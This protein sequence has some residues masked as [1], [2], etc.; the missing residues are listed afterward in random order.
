[1]ANVSIDYVGPPFN[2]ALFSE[3]SAAFGKVHCR[4]FGFRDKVSAI[5]D[6]AASSLVGPFSEFCSGTD[7]AEYDLIF[8][9]STRC[10]F[11][12]Q[13]I[14]PASK[15]LCCVHNVEADYATFNKSNIFTRTNIASS[16]RR[17]L[18]STAKLLFMHEDDRKRMEELYGVSLGNFGYHPVCSFGTKQPLLPVQQRKSRIAFVGSLNCNYNHDG[19]VTFLE[20][21]WPGL[22]DSGY[23]L[24]IAG[25]NPQGSLLR[26]ASNYPNVQVISNPEDVTSL[27][28]DSRIMILPDVSGAGM[29]VRVAEA[30]SCGVPVV[31]THLGLKGYADVDS[32]GVQT[33]SIEEM[34][35]AIKELVSTD[36][37][38]L[39]RLAQGAASAWRSSYSFESFATRLSAVVTRTLS[40]PIQEVSTLRC[41][42]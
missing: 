6:H 2:P 27:L 25:R 9:E 8:L 3:E 36:L 5:A 40:I 24:V 18:Q 42:K 41:S 31:G 33:E 10:G 21:C 26:A 35:S 20:S 15:C 4:P 29:K 14:P 19:I 39:E 28:L 1:M 7:L 11:V 37:S 34:G 13:R 17:I 16:E 12:F 38:K 32:F 23:E 22:T 30:L